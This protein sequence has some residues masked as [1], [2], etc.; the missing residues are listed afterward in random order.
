MT[1]APAERV[2]TSLEEIAALDFEPEVPC[3]VKRHGK[4]APGCHGPSV[5]YAICRLCDDVRPV[6]GGAVEWARAAAVAAD[7]FACDRCWG[8]AESFDRLYRL[9]P[10]KP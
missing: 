10:I 3:S 7:G 8:S 4:G 9:E 2:E 6:C 1:I 5:W